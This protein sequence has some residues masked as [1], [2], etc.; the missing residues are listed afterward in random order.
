MSF[1]SRSIF[2]R[3]GLSVAVAMTMMSSV[4]QA[5]E[6]VYDLGEIVV[7]AARTAQTVDE[8]LAPVTVISREQ[9]ERSQATSVTELLNQAPGVQ[10][11]F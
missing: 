7:T 1:N 5:E 8:T 3:T 2:A 11:S 9:I 6:E 10:I 4:A